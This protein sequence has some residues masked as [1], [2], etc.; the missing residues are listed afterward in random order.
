MPGPVFISQYELDQVRSEQ[1]QAIAEIGGFGDIKRPSYAA[2][3]YGGSTTTFTTQSDVAMRLWI[4]SGTNGTAEETRF[5]GD[6]ELSQTDAFIVVPYGTDITI[7]DQ[8][9]YDDREWM[10]VGLQTKDTF[11]TAIKARVKAMR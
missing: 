5:W 9:H 6:Q 2:D 4:S 10:V 3:G 8:I 11:A 1:A 7:N